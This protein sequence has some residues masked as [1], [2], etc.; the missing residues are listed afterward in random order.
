MTEQSDRNYLMGHTNRERRR[1][2]LQA[3]IEYRVGGEPESPY[4][5]WYAESLRTVFPRVVSLGLVTAEGIDID[6]FEQRP[7]EEVSHSMPE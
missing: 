4:Y 5:E 6:T 2:L 1:L 7:R 3:G